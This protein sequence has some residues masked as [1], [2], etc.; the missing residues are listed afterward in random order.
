MR[1]LKLD[2]WACNLPC[3]LP[4]KPGMPLRA[5]ALPWLTPTFPYPAP[6]RKEAVEVEV[7]VEVVQVDAP[8][9]RRLATAAHVADE[10]PSLS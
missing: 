4:R 7:E 5:R 2:M 1:I 3:F 8:V 6:A 9:A 10:L